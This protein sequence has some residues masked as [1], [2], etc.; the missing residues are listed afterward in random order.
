MIKPLRSSICS[1]PLAA[2]QK[3]TLDPR[4]FHESG[5]SVIRRKSII[6]SLVVAPADVHDI[7]CDHDAI[8][9]H[10][11]FFNSANHQE[12]RTIAIFV[13]VMKSGA[14]AEAT[15]VCDEHAGIKSVLL[16]E[17]LWQDIVV[18]E[19]VDGVHDAGHQAARQHTQKVEF[20]VYGS[21]P[22]GPL[23]MDMAVDALN[24]LLEAFLF[25]IHTHFY[26][27]QFCFLVEL[28]AHAERYVDIFFVVEPASR[29]EL[30]H[31]RINTQRVPAVATSKWVMLTSVPKAA[32]APDNR[33]S[34]RF[35]VVIVIADR[36]I[37]PGMINGELA[38]DVC[39]SRFHHRS[40]AVELQ[41]LVRVF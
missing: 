23:N 1:R 15:E 3:S 39:L 10:G 21:L 6:D 4:G 25:L 24:G 28:R 13:E 32:R 38:A 27:A 9:N 40:V 14:H 34:C 41:G 31:G 18:V 30:V 12:E 7:L 20:L 37:L 26:C 29:D 11:A 2:P 8:S 36:F 19:P 22:P 5:H 33:A 35:D 16:H 17:E